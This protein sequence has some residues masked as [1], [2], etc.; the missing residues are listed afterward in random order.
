ML[1]FQKLVIRFGAFSRRSYVEGEDTYSDEEYDDE[2]ILFKEI[3]TTKIIK[4]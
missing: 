3:Q 1:L 2:V 4:M